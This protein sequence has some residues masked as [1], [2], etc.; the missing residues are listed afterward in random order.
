MRKLLS[1]PLKIIIWVYK[2]LSC[3][4]NFWALDNLCIQDN[5]SAF[6]TQDRD[7]DH[8]CPQA[9]IIVW[10]L[11]RLY[12]SCI[13]C[14]FFFNTITRKQHL[15]EADWQWKDV[16]FYWKM[17]KQPWHSDTFLYIMN[18]IWKKN[19]YFFRFFYH[20]HGKLG[21]NSAGCDYPACT[22]SSDGALPLIFVFVC[23]GM[24][25]SRHRAGERCGTKYDCCPPSPVGPGC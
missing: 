20:N 23:G 18:T 24:R 4:N 11:C 22:G 9:I 1:C 13:C 7:L 10:G 25:R 5:L 14:R 8:L 2:L 17:V 21:E 6:V 3:D 19:L 12:S 15:Y 16:L